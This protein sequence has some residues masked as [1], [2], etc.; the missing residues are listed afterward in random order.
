MG[1]TAVFRRM[2][3]QPH[4]HLLT[5]LIAGATFANEG[6]PESMSPDSVR[7]LME[8]IQIMNTKAFCFDVG[9]I[10]RIITMKY[11][12]AKQV[13]GVPLVSEPTKCDL[14]VGKLLLKG[15][16]PCRMSLYTE[17][18]GTVSATHFHKYCNNYCKGCAFVQFYG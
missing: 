5:F 1:E 18:L 13:L 7:I 4:N 3:L 11:G 14:C 6:D 9:L 8:N 2:H 17:S 10:R 12:P 15:D 16:R